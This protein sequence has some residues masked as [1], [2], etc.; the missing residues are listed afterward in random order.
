[1][2]TLSN[3]LKNQVLQSLLA[4]VVLVAGGFFIFGNTEG[5]AYQIPNSSQV[6]IVDNGYLFGVEAQDGTVAELLT[7]LG[8][9]IADNDLVFPGRD[10]RVTIGTRIY[11]FRSSKVTLVVDG[12]STEIETHARTVEDLLNEQ[13]IKLG[14]NDKIDPPLTAL[15]HAHDK[16]EVIRVSTKEVTTEEVVEFTTQHVN[17]D[18][19]ALG[20]TKV[21]Q[22]G[23][24]GKVKRKYL[25]TYE[26]GKEVDREVLKEEVLEEAVKQIVL[27]GTKIET[28]YGGTGVASWYFDYTNSY[29]SSSCAAHR[30]LPKGTRVKVTN[31]ANGKS[32]IVTIN[33]RGPQS[34]SRIIDLG[35]TPFSK[36][37]SLSAG[38]IT[39]RLDVIQ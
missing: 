37:G 15:L 33:D 12:K 25:I 5:L 13:N 16:V 24:N 14:G 22:A 26:D 2:T 8:Y 32:V 11:I 3:T 18:T 36:I 34:P 35:R 31:T 4:F 7:N 39:V 19:L 6:S 23:K 9:N 20:T 29:C 1:M 27:V 17:D 30:T 21:K 10:D 38:L 28:V